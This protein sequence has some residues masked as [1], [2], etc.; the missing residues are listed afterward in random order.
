MIA[1]LEESI[2]KLDEQID[3]LERDIEGAGSA[4]LRGRLRGTL[5]TSINTRARLRVILERE[6]EKLI[7]QNKP[8]GAVDQ[9]AARRRD[10]MTGTDS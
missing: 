10:R 9:L 7:A 4:E 6:R 1:E 8:K 5:A 3:G 2:A